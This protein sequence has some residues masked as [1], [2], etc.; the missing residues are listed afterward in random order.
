MKTN[1]L[2]DEK[3]LHRTGVEKKGLAVR[4]FSTNVHSTTPLVP[5]IASNKR[6]ANRLPAY[7]CD[8]AEMKR[9][10]E[11]YEAQDSTMK[12]DIVKKMT[13]RPWIK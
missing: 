2:G 4:L 13:N 6:V 1:A 12:N 3:T 11:L 8:E 5:E 7:A 9:V 10:I